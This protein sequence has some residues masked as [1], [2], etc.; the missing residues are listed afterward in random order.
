MKTNKLFSATVLS[1][2]L[3]AT[4]CTK[5]NVDFA[6]APTSSDNEKTTMAY[7]STKTFYPSELFAWNRDTKIGYTNNNG[8]YTW[9]TDLNQ[10]FNIETSGNEQR[11]IAYTTCHSWC[12]GRAEIQKESIWNFNGSDH[13]MR[14]EGNFMIPATALDNGINDPKMDYANN[15]AEF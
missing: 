15:G 8:V 11:L 1:L 6:A 5:Q 2:L 12:K 4:A 7:N 10:Q 9:V 3:A 13:Y 14:L